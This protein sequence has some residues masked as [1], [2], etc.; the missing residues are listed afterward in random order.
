MDLKTNN[1]NLLRQEN[2]FDLNSI[3]KKTLYDLNQNLMKRQKNLTI[4]IWIQLKDRKKL[5][6]LNLNSFKQETNKRFHLRSNQ[7]QGYNTFKEP[8]TTSKQRVQRKSELILIF[9]SDQHTKSGK[10]NGSFYLWKTIHDQISRRHNFSKDYFL[11][12]FF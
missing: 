8:K 1:D 4:W 2:N 7:R 9:S 6:D 3:K 5:Y 12:G 11:K 10:K